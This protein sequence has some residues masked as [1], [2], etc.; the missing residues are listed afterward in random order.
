MGVDST[1]GRTNIGWNYVRVLA[2][3]VARLSIVLRWHSSNRHGYNQRLIG[4]LCA[5]FCSQCGTQVI[6]RALFCTKC[7]K[8]LSAREP[9]VHTATSTPDRG[10]AGSTVFYLGVGLCAIACVGIFSGNASI[11]APF[12]LVGIPLSLYGQYL[13]NKK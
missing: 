2:V 8:A 9:V 12:G 11:L 7:G 1:W 10:N 6:D 3:G 13:L 4:E 5:M